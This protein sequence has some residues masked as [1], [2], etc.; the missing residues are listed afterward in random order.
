VFSVRDLQQQ[1]QQHQ[2]Q[3]LDDV[4]RLLF[5]HYKQKAVAL[6]KGLRWGGHDANTPCFDP[7]AEMHH[8]LATQSFVDPPSAQ[9]M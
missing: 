8:A 9:N 4:P 7:C 5:C 3:W 6:H 1:Q 2:Q